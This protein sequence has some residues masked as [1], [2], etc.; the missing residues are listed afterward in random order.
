MLPDLSPAKTGVFQSKD[1][2]FPLVKPAVSPTSRLISDEL[3]P[4]HDRP[5]IVDALSD[6]RVVL[7]LGARQVGKSTLTREVGA[8]AMNA[9]VLTLDD[10]TTR[11]AANND[12][13][14]FIAALDSAV[15]ID[16]V[17]RAPDLLLAI[18]E[19]VDADQRPG[20]FLLTGSANILTA[21]KIYDAL[22]GRTEIVNLWPLSQGEIE[23]STTNIVDLLFAGSP[24]Q[25]TSA[26]IG[27]E[28]FVDRVARGGYPEAR[29]RSGARRRKWFESYLKTLIERDLREISDAQKLRDIPK[30][31]RRLAAQAANLYS[32][33]SIAEKIHLGD[34]TVES[35][36]ALLET[37]F[38]VQ[39]KRGWVP[40]IGS[41]EVQKEK[42]YITD[43]GLLA[44]L[45]GADEKRIATD[46]QITGKI[47]ENFVAM[48][49]A[50]HA[51][52]AETSTEQ[53]YYRVRDD[54]VDVILESFSGE[55][56]AVETKVAATVKAS[57]YRQ[58]QKLRDARGKGFIAGVVLYTG[59]DTKPLSD[60]LWAVPV[61][62][63]WS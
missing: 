61:S 18:K 12:P 33:K 47:F 20:R 52:W 4:R 5:L 2:S 19:R 38:L 35:Y 59:A 8:D 44:Y 14:G 13:T 23:H 3:F 51:D 43:S 7:V 50:R 53:Y 27:R 60:R 11:E 56:V 29:L 36:S 31:L 6:T 40:G 48:E 1:R 22:T 25:I 26:P 16:E 54:E 9:Q 32:A 42:V 62:A 10:K 15:L 55:I 17:Q 58:L 45:L 41:R 39:R 30:L 37:V 21:P 34:E 49:I 28:A 24:P 46:D 63:L 57:D